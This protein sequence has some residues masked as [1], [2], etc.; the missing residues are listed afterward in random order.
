MRA[1][2]RRNRVRVLEAAEEAFSAEG[3]SVPIDEI[4]RRAGVGA[5]TVYRHFPTKE[6]LFEA[7]ILGHVRRLVDDARSLTRAE[8]PG[9]AF[10]EFWTRMVEEGSA[11]KDLHDALAGAGL[12]LRAA[13]G[14]IVQDLRGAI[15]EL[16]TRAQQAGSVREDM[17]VEEL[18]VL[19]ASTSLA[20]RHRSHDARLP[21]RLAAIIRDGLR[22]P[23]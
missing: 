15:G 1:D 4:A 21:G 6:A 14:E 23:P 17:G 12:D 7:I 8:N 19:L 18:M 10:F 20:L 5:G 16:L 13:S 11:T 2:A 22:P 9:Q 3:L